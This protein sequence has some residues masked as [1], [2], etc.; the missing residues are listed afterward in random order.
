M[1]Q[2]RGWKVAT[3]DPHFGYGYNADIFIHS[4][5]SDIGCISI[6][7]KPQQQHSEVGMFTA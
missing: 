4:S 5:E 7:S 1:S 2:K 3:F 6:F